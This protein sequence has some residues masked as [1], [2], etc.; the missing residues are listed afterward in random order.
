MLACRSYLGSHV[1]LSSKR[2]FKPSAL[3]RDELMSIIS[4]GTRYLVTLANTQ[5]ARSYRLSRLN[6]DGDECK[7]E[8]LPCRSYCGILIRRCQQKIPF[9][10]FVFASSSCWELNVAVVSIIYYHIIVS[11]L[12][13]TIE[14]CLRNGWGS[15]C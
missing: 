4:G 12:V 9:L 1:P 7:A 11:E 5:R 8:A 2:G 6:L 13:P 3:N 14:L 10:F 15:S